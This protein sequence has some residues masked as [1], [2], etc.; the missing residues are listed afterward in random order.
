MVFLAR[1]LDDVFHDAVDAF[2]FRMKS[3]EAKLVAGYQINNN[4]STD[5]QRKPEYANRAVSFMTD[6]IADGGLDIVAEHCDEFD[7]AQRIKCQLSIRII[8]KR[9]RIALVCR[10]YGSDT[11]GVRGEAAQWVLPFCI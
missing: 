10:P 5:A 11:T 2:L 7:M 3:V 4:R 9:L 1:A 8:I 6:Q